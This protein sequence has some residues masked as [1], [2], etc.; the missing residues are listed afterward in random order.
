MS[1][2]I[3]AVRS[4]HAGILSYISQQPARMKQI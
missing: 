1:I 3:Q 4:T 2:N